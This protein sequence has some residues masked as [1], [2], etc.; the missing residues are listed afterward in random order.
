MS[1]ITVSKRAK[2]EGWAYLLV[3]P[4]LAVILLILGYPVVRLFTL[5]FQKYGL[6]EIMSGATTWVGFENFTTLLKDPE[7]WNVLKRTFIFTGAMVAASIVIAAWIAHM[8]VKMHP[9]IRW[10][11][12]S[13]L[14]MVWAIP[15]LVGISIWKWMFSF[16]FSIITTTINRLGF[17]FEQ[18]N[19]FTN[20]ISGFAIIGA[21]VVW[22]AIPFLA[23][24][25]YAALTQ[26]P[27]DLIE[28]ASIDGANSRQIFRRV[29]LPIL[30]P[31]YVILISLSVIWDFQV[32][33]QIW[34]VLDNRP[35][36]EYFTMSIYAFQKSFGLSEYGMGAATAILMIFALLGATWFY[37]RKMVQI[38]DGNE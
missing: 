32:F 7:F 34:V 30:L 12:N 8:M 19:W 6:D 35:S 13:T 25:I 21:I 31:V 23:I 33:T 15:A 36:D 28:A 2:R 5:S 20:P 24:S 14:I 29:I 18:R 16:D 3:A 37:I 11:L 4:A 27:K 9:A 38:G 26:V 1:P 10:A 22:G 17:T